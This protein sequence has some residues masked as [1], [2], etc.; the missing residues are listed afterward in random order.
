MS[1]LLLFRFDKDTHLLGVDISELLQLPLSAPEEV[2]YMHDIR[3]GDL[4]VFPELSPYPGQEA[5]LVL[6][7][8][9]E[10]AVEAEH[11]QL[12]FA[13]AGHEALRLASLR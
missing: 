12:E 6:G 1:L 5:R 8:S 7:S 13:V 4:G 11:L 2:L 3:P 9:E 10:V